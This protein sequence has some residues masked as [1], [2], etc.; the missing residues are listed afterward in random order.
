MKNSASTLPFPFFFN[1]AYRLGELNLA[2][3]AAFAFIDLIPNT[4]P[5]TATK[6][7]NFLLFVLV[8]DSHKLRNKFI[9][10]VSLLAGFD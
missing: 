9:H 2:L 10:K 3:L 1:F 6:L 4:T 8:A 7:I 5:I